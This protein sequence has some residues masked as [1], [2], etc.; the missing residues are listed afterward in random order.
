[1]SAA[2]YRKSR[3]RWLESSVMLSALAGSVL[4]H[5]AVVL[6]LRPAPITAAKPLPVLSVRLSGTAAQ[7]K[8]TQ[9]P[10]VA[11][12]TENASPA[13]EPPP[14]PSTR[15]PDARSGTS[16]TLIPP[17]NTPEPAAPPAAPAAVARV[18]VKPAPKPKHSAKPIPTKSKAQEAKATR[19][20]LE[21]VSA[22]AR[23]APVDS[24]ISSVAAT[25]PTHPAPTAQVAPPA[26]AQPR[27]ATDLASLTD[28]AGR[29]AAR[30]SAPGLKIRPPRYPR[31]A[32]R[33]GLE[34]RVI[35]RVQVD[36]NGKATSVM[37]AQSSGHDILDRAARKAI[38][39]WRF[40]PAEQ[41]GRSLASTIEIP[42]SFRL[43][44]DA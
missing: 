27:E 11:A 19:Q 40:M 30:Y 31:K 32:R 39:R 38:G 9:V 34:G 29:Q 33:L 17:V 8:R 44:D 4:V 20:S 5:A 15:P 6:S 16:P 42:V 13:R 3:R 25:E 28:Q 26:K 23:L 35:L 14:H 43:E 36:E 7:P 41:R 37:I 10:H 22:N 1:M 21:P 12:M 18:P 24:P 2:S